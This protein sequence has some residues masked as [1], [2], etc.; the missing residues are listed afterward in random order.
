MSVIKTYLGNGE[1]LGRH[2]VEDSEYAAFLERLTNDW[3]VARII[4]ERDG[5]QVAVI[6]CR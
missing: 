6:A 3:D 2:V 5:R 1:R 4:V